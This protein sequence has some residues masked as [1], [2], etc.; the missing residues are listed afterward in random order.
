MKIRARTRRRSREKPPQPTTAPARTP[1]VLEVEAIAPGYGEPSKTR[2]P[3]SGRGAFADEAAVLL[4]L[5]IAGGDLTAHQA[6]HVI[7]AK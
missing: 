5:A 1:A 7:G 6:I 3:W 4:A 2:Y